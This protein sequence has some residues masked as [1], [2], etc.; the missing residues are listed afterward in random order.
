MNINTL[1][2]N[3]IGA[4]AATTLVAGC[5]DNGGDTT[6]QDARF[7]TVLTQQNIDVDRDTARQAAQNVCDDLDKSTDD[8][9]NIDP[10][11]VY[12][13]AQKI[14]IKT[15]LSEQDAAKLMGASVEAYCPEYKAGW[16]K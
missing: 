5:S 16:G 10:F 4:I 7:D 8:P 3:L 6:E 1:C 2:A 14:A 13:I 9:S 11:E 12:R 15:D